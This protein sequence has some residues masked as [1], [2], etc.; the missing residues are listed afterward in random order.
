MSCGQVFFFFSVKFTFFLNSQNTFFPLTHFCRI[1]LLGQ[2]DATLTDVRGHGYFFTRKN[3][4]TSIII[5]QIS[6]YERNC[7]TWK[8]IFAY[9]HW[10]GKFHW[11]RMT[12]S[13]NVFFWTWRE[14]KAGDGSAYLSQ[15]KQSDSQNY[16][17]KLQVLR[18]LVHNAT[19][20]SLHP[21]L[22]LPMNN[23]CPSN[24]R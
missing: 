15:Y 18:V 2:N 6:S 4:L 23:F 8:L 13:R 7:L 21:F 24:W 1:L 5:T 9:I 10:W 12:A 16:Q 17:H 22:R 14:L 3:V 20:S 11:I 19:V